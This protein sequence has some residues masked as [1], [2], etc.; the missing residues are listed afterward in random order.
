MM[1]VVKIIA[2]SLLIVLLGFDA[3]VLAQSNTKFQEANERYGQGEFELAIEKYQSILQTG[4][5]SAELYYNLA[6]A[7]YKLNN[8]APSIFY[9]EKALQL[10]PNDKDI[11]NN[12]A[13]AQNMTI[14]AVPEVPEVGFNKLYKNWVNAFSF[15]SWSHLAIAFSVAFVILFLIYYFSQS[16]LKKRL[17]FVLGFL[18]IVGSM[19]TLFMAFQKFEFD[20]QNIAA[21]VFESVID[22]KSEPNSDSSNLFKLHEGTK[23]KVLDSVANW[24]RIQLPDGLSGWIP[25]NAIK[26]L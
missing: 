25:S 23:V 18:C 11:Q 20:K 14:D 19:F 8:V 17:T 10:N 15:D 2:I 5:H 24:R 21:V 6:N 12:L 13:F 16:T 22:I 9:Y 7:H 26:V 3:L 1:K 4:E